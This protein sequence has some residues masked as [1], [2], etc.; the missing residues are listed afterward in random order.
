MKTLQLGMGWFPEQAGGLNR[1]YYDCMQY[2]PAAGV[3]MRGLVAGSP[4]V[5]QTSGG[6]VQAFAPREASLLQRWRGVRQAVGKALAEENYPLV[7]SHFALYT[8]PVLDRLG[9]RPLVMHFQGPWALEGRVEGGKTLSTWFKR[10]LEQTAYRRMTQFIV[11]SEAFRNILNREYGVPL[12][13]IHVVP[14]GVAVER[15]DPTLPRSVARTQLGWPQDRPILLAVRRLAKR[16]GLENLIAAMAQVRREHPDAL[17]MIAG[18]GALGTTLQAQIEELNLTEN[19]RL[20]GFVSD[21]DLALAYRAANFSVVPTVALE[22]FGLIVIES[23]A[24]GTPVL[25]T[26]VDS[27][28]EILRP[29]SEDLVFESSAAEHLAQGISEALSGLRQLPSE[30]ACIDYVQQ[31][32]TWP[33][34]ASRVKSVYQAALTGD[35]V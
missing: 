25:G 26:P 30:Q 29:F 16:M 34:I 1:V 24:A 13:R 9:R 31:H 33:V 6:Q 17:L 35:A 28:P 22:G 4:A 23:L 10:Q 5:A 2:L 15:F 27:I 3:Q 12:E 8:F 11:L 19:V 7:V 32:Y 14:P 21:Q 20:L 18:K